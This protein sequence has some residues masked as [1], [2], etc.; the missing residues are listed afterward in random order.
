MKGEN[1]SKVRN[2]GRGEAHERNQNKIPGRQI[3]TEHFGRGS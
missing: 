3:Y 2:W 1:N